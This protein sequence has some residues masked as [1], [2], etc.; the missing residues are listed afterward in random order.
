MKTVR[1][2]KKLNPVDILALEKGS[3]IVDSINIP[4]KE[5]EAVEKAQEI[6]DKGGSKINFTSQAE[7]IRYS[8]EYLN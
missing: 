1:L 2:R 6:I 3:L 7:I 5:V 8:F 4:F